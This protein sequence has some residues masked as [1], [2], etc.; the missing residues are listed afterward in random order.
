M[1]TGWKRYSSLARRPAISIAIGH[2]RF[3][4]NSTEGR[5]T[6]RLAIN[7]A[8]HKTS[9][10]LGLHE[11]SRSTDTLTFV[12]KKN[13]YF[14]PLP[15][16]KILS[17]NLAFENLN[18]GKHDMLLH[19]SFFMHRQLFVRVSMKAS[20][21]KKIVGAITRFTVVVYWLIFDFLDENFWIK[22]YLSTNPLRSS[23]SL[24]LSS[25]AFP[26]YIFVDNLSVSIST[27]KNRRH[28][29]SFY[30]YRVSIFLL[31]SENYD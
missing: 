10:S 2:A 12:K 19:F 4:R 6:F 23:F 14:F 27:C 5:R 24:S 20:V 21:C 26:F 25:Y 17:D 3:V 30:S 31:F 8:L 16:E 18:L 7:V 13:F 1:Q 29:Y 9:F 28:D 22:I 11:T 15:L